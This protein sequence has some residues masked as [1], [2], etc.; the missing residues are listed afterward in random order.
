MFCKEDMESC[1]Q[2]GQYPGS[3]GLPRSSAQDRFLQHAHE[4]RLLARGR[5]RSLQLLQQSAWIPSAL[6]LH[7][8]EDLRN[9]PSDQ[10]QLGNSVCLL[11][12]LAHKSIK[13]P[14]QKQERVLTSHAEDAAA[15]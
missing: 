7:R 11:R 15:P 8:R 6:L 9:S 12:I 10:A 1:G 14:L 5:L 13:Q 2:S 3:E 4:Q